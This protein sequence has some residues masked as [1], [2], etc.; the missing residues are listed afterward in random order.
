MSFVLTKILWM[1]LQPSSLI[2]IGFFASIIIR[3]WRPRLGNAV[4]AATATLYLVCG[5]SPVGNWLL[6]PL[7]GRVRAFSPDAAQ[8]AAGIIV[9][10][11]AVDTINS[12]RRNKP[13]LNEA[14]ERMTEAVRLAKTYP[15]LPVVFSG[16]S[17]EIVYR[18]T[19]EAA[20]A[21]DFF[22][23][24]GLTPPRL[25][26]E[27]RSRNTRENAAYTAAL[28]QPKPDRPWILVTSAFHMPRAKA[29]FEANG[30]TI[31]PYPV[32]FRTRGNEDRWRFF[33]QP[34][35]GLR[36]VDLAV[37]EWVGLGLSWLAGDIAWPKRGHAFIR[38]WKTHSTGPG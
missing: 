9:L 27:D 5:I 13:Q 10:G 24:F 4:F 3:R 35:E 6:I 26:L 22:A 36:R 28:V 15:A 16:G 33:P 34:S 29:Q 18:D 12:A 11:G 30:F 23:G 25:Q 21:K 2:V 20:V 17:G 38:H 31:L 19:S 14:A 37:K 32:D 8:E 1:L 7:E